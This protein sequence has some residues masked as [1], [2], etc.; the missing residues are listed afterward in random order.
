LT[1]GIS[2]GFGVGIWSFDAE[3]ARSTSS[4]N[5]TEG[6][7]DNEVFSRGGLRKNRPFYPL[8][9]AHPAPEGFNPKTA[10]AEFRINLLAAE[11]ICRLYHRSFP[12]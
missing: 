3:G 1:F 4:P 12:A 8:A 9:L 2:L 7:E 6:H 5:Q 11:T 10:A